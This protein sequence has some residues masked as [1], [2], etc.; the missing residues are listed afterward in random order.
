MLNAMDGVLGE[1]TQRVSRMR[2]LAIQSASD[3]LGNTEREYVSDEYRNIIEDIDRITRSADFNGL[4]LLPSSTATVSIQIGISE[5]G[6][7]NRLRVRLRPLDAN[8]LG[9]G[10][11][12]V[13][14]AADAQQ[15]VTRIDDAIDAVNGIRAEYGANQNQLG[16]ALRNLENWTENMVEAES[17]IRDTDIAFEAANLTRQQVFRQV[18]V[19]ML[20]QTGTSKSAALSLI[21]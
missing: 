3:V 9:L 2:E 20:A 14:S 4:D 8:A 6:P 10:V 16:S 15:A 5:S 21:G 18:G 13:D 19:A 7:E 12:R 11:T 17:R 1:V